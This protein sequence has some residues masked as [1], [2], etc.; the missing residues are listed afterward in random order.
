[1][2]PPP[3]ATAG[4]VDELSRLVQMHDSGTLSDADFVTAKAQLLG[5]ARADAGAMADRSGP[6]VRDKDLV[7]RLAQ[8][9]LWIVLALL[10]LR[11]VAVSLATLRRRATRLAAAWW[12]D[13]ERQE[14]QGAR[15]AQIGVVASRIR[16][17]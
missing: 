4:E 15:H 3:A 9:L 10:L 11:E 13:V 17:R 2:A 16:G 1:M 6:P 8:A 12:D 14:R 7:A 5:P